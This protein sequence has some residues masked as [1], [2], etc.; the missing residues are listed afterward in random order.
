MTWRSDGFYFTK[1]PL[2]ANWH[3]PRYDAIFE[4][5]KRIE[6]LAG[7]VTVNNDCPTDMGS[8]QRAHYLSLTST[9]AVTLC[10]PTATPVTWTHIFPL[11][12][13]SAL[14]VSLT[15]VFWLKTPAG[16]PVAEGVG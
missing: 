15:D 9:Q 7:D 14:P 16:V 10:P 6:D 2:I 11:S 12:S 8:V 1:R 5:K 4:W 3:A 13:M